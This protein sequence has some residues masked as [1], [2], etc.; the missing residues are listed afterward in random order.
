[1]DFLFVEG[2]ELPCGR[3]TTGSQVGAVAAKSEVFSIKS[4][5]KANRHV[6]NDHVAVHQLA[7]T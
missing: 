5:A 2:K 6:S 1:M 3:T 4:V 7:F